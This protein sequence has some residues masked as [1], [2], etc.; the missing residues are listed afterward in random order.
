MMYNYYND[1]PDLMNHKIYTTQ[2]QIKSVIK[3]FDTAMIHVGLVRSSDTG[4]LDTNNIPDLDIKTGLN[5]SGSMDYYRSNGTYVQYLPL[6]YCFTDDAQA[7]SPIYIK[8][9]FE[10]ARIN[11]RYYQ[12]VPANAEFKFAAILGTTWQVG[13]STDGI[14]NIQNPVTYYAGPFSASG[15]YNYN[16]QVTNQTNYSYQ[17]SVIHF[18]KEKGILMV[19]VCPGYRV[20][21]SD[22]IS[23]VNESD[24]NLN[25]SL[26]NILVFRVDDETIGTLGY[27]STNTMGIGGQPIRK[28]FRFITKNKIYN[29]DRAFSVSG[30][31]SDRPSI[32]N[33]KII[34]TPLNGIN[35]FNNTMVRVPHILVSSRADTGNNNGMNMNV[36]INENEKYNYYTYS[37]IESGFQFTTP[38]GYSQNLMIYSGTEKYVK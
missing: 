9:I 28:V 15:Q 27:E 17:N 30:F 32:V 35:A 26:V 33:G 1:Y 12:Y 22:N 37:P 34:L 10:I 36:I 31:Y 4:Q 14:S 16:Y 7:T 20:G 11:G 24:M 29:D 13:N 21:V 25:N 5:I 23:H 18:N 19:N 6:V 38:W 8:I 2:D 3:Q